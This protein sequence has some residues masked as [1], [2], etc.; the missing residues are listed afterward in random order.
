MDSFYGLNPSNIA[1][2]KLKTGGGVLKPDMSGFGDRCPCG[3]EGRYTHIIDGKT[4]SSCNKH[5]VCKSYDEVFEEKERAKN[6]MKILLKAAED[7]KNYKE[8]SSF[9]KQAVF[10]VAHLKDLYG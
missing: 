9:Y 1:E 5:S 2:N 7:L 10:Q 4:V 3:R 6:A 8:S